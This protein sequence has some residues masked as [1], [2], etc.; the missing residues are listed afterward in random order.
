[1]NKENELMEEKA[2]AEFGPTGQSGI[3]IPEVINRAEPR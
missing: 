2:L 1:V 3:H